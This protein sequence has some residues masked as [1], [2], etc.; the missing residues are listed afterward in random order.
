M[1]LSRAG[2]R[3]LEVSCQGIDE[4]AGRVFEVSLNQDPYAAKSKYTC[5]ELVAQAVA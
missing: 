2:W 3:G 1:R 5:P 4:Q